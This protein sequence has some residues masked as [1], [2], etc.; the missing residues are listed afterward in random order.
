MLLG[1][2]GLGG[3]EQTGEGG[4]LPPLERHCEVFGEGARM[5]F[6]FFCCH[7]LLTREP[8][9]TTPWGSAR[10]LLPDSSTCKQSP[11]PSSVFSRNWNLLL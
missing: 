6:I 2:L 10:L 1:L 8:M 9:G 7:D 3:K 5:H 11:F 4:L